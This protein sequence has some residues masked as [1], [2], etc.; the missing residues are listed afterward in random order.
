MARKWKV[1]DVVRTKDTTRKRT[2]TLFVVEAR[3]IDGSNAPR[4]RGMVM[5]DNEPSRR[6]LWTGAVHVFPQHRYRLVEE[7]EGDT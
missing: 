2:I 7:D 4:F 1:G 5:D 3:Y 6:R